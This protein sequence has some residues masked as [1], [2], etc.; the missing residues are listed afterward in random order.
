MSQVQTRSQGL[1]VCELCDAVMSVNVQ[2]CSGVAWDKLKVLTFQ[3]YHHSGS[4]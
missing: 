3:T 4:G 1:L 2:S